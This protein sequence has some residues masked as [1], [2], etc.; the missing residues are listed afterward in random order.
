MASMLASGTWKNL[1]F[2]LK[3]CS[4][5]DRDPAMKLICS[6]ALEFQDAK[7]TRLRFGG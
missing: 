5:R 3:S 1:R 6:N 7:C 4:L 2:F